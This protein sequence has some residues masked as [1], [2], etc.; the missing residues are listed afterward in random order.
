MFD[1][2]ANTIEQLSEVS[3]IHGLYR[4]VLSLQNIGVG[5]YAFRYTGL[6]F[7]KSAFVDMV[8][9][10][11]HRLTGTPCLTKLKLCVIRRGWS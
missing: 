1:T 11:V 2:L 10:R 7:I 4:A 8:S 6:S 9:S 3:L 5:L